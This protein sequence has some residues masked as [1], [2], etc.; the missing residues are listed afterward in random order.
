MKKV[1]V[2]L[3]SLTPFFSWSQEKPIIISGQVFVDSIPLNDVHIINKALEV[4]T[5][6]EDNGFFE[7]LVKKGDA[8]IISHISLN[9]KEH[10]ITEENITSKKLRFSLDNKSYMLNEVVI[11]KTKGIF[12][13]DKDIMTH[14]ASVVNAKILNLPY[15]NS[16]RPKKENLVSLKSGAAVNLAGLVNALNGNTKRE[17][18]LKKL[19]FE[20]Q[21]LLGIREHFTDGFFTRQLKI[22]EGYINQFLNYSISSGIIQLYKKEKHLE[23]TTVLLETS[24]TFSNKEKKQNEVVIID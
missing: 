8:L 24:K 12:H 20:D 15:A 21:N 6:T 10:I 16:K 5:I 18:K 22:K 3:L 23:L 7:I 19:K 14:N 4:G 17:K 2:L 11:G 9:V 1:I 13:V